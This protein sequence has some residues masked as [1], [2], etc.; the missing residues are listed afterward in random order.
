MLLI[1][2]I[3]QV[4]TLRGEAAPRR[5]HSMAE[6]GIVENGAVLIRGEHIVWVGPTRDLPRGELDAH[7][8]TF[9]CVGLDL[10]ALPG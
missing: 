4:V 8:E 10:V 9:D 2:N 6:L 3:G 1:K 5:A 7:Y